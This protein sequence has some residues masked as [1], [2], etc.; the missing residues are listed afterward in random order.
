M[1]MPP[2]NA[3]QL[4]A[5]SEPIHATSATFACE[6][7]GAAFRRHWDPVRPTTDDELQL[8]RSCCYPV[9][10]TFAEDATDAAELGAPDHPYD[11]Q[12]RI[13]RQR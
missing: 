6:S 2:D 12:P 10:A 7:F 9:P 13:R 3:I 5:A 11:P 1:A 4:A 8:L